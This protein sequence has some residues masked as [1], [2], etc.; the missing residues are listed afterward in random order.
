M[1]AGE[2]PIE[3]LEVPVQGAR[4]TAERDAL[5]R[6]MR[7]LGIPYATICE[8]FG[9]SRQ[10]V[11]QITRARPGAAGAGSGSAERPGQRGRF[12][13]WYETDGSEVGPPRSGERDIVNGVLLSARID[14]ERAR[15]ESGSFAAAVRFVFGPGS[16]FETLSWWAGFDPELYRRKA[17]SL[18]EARGLLGPERSLEELVAEALTGPPLTHDC[19]VD[20][21]EREDSPEGGE[22]AP[23]GRGVPEGALAT[24][25]ALC[26][27][28]HVR[29]LDGRAA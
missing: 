20:V 11:H 22:E 29:A 13:H 26:A 25:I 28:C 6:E 8:R 24:H 27:L 9:I 5:I 2:A 18:L 17:R 14:L 23:C 7:S 10:R 15:P 4:S 1:A 16:R 12:F 21:G 19:Y 3:G